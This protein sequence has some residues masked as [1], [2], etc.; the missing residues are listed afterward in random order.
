VRAGHRFNRKSGLARVLRDPDLRTKL[1]ITNEQYAKLQT[2]FLNSSKNAIRGKADLKIKRL[3]LAQL[4][5]EDKV[6]RAQVEQKVNE[7]SALHASLLKNQIEARLAIRETLT[8]D[9]LSK[10]REW[11]HTQGRGWM[12]ERM[13]RR[14]GMMRRPG[15]SPQRP[16]VPPPSAP[17]NPGDQ[18]DQP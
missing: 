7:I 17:H 12:Q 10:L 9:Q 5:N 6:D 1:G 18:P 16:P 2:A 14:M 8:A 11:R 13:Q 15:M 4:M 3:E